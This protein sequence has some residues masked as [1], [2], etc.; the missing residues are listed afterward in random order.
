[1]NVSIEFKSNVFFIQ[2]LIRKE[3]IEKQSPKQKQK[4]RV[5]IQALQTED[6]Q[7]KNELYMEKKNT[8]CIIK[9]KIQ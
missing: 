5:H 4:Q 7:H 8:K 1:M 2:T 3:T 6:N 9:F